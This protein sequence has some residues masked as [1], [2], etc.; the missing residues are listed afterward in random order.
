MFKVRRFILILTLSLTATVWN[1]GQSK[2]QAI[3]PPMRIYV[4]FTAVWNAAVETLENDNLR[5]LDQNRG[6]GSIRTRF[7]EYISGSLTEDHL[8]KIGEAPRLI[9]G[10]WVRVNYQYEILIEFIQ[11]KETVI[12]V[13]ANIEA[14]E[15]NFLG[16]EKWLPIQSNGNLEEKLL[17]NFGQSLF[18]QS[19]NLQKPKKG[20][21][22]RDPVYLPLP[23]NQIPFVAGPERP[24]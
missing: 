17:I 16:N 3:P 10:E 12:T 22:E 24:H 7:R 18:G 5:V 19:F 4:P 23:T 6:R 1:L 13:D 11:E 14:L 8:G 15:R 9:D 21:W 20:Y 2:G